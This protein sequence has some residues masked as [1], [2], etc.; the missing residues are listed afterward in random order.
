MFGKVDSPFAELS[1]LNK[2]YGSVSAIRKSSQG[3]NIIIEVF[4]LN[5]IIRFTVQLETKS[6]HITPTVNPFPL[7][8]LS[9]T[10]GTF[11]ACVLLRNSVA[12]T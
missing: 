1:H 10:L 7:A 2:L 5:P 6:T 11:L 8:T 12:V 9:L 3:K 4:S